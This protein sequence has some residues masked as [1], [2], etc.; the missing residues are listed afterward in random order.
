MTLE[1]LVI[2]DD[3]CYINLVIDRSTATLPPSISSTLGRPNLKNLSSFGGTD[4]TINVIEQIGTRYMD[5]GV[6]ILN[7]HSGHYVSS[8]RDQFLRNAEDI[9]RKI[10]MEWMRGRQG[11]KLVEWSV[12]A[13]ILHDIGLQCLASDIR[14]TL[15]L[16]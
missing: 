5:F 14:R 10:L 8:L 9:N 3:P 4:R 1:G 15:N 6:R 16:N 13:T 11:A 12:L 2:G 7:D